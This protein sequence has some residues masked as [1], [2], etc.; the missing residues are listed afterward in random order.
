MTNNELLKNERIGVLLWK[1][2]VPAIIGMLVNALYNVVDRMYIG[3]L[4]P[5]AMTGIGLSLPLMTILMGFGMLVGIG[6]GAR[7]SIRL[8]QGRKEDAEHI[9]GNAFTLLTLIMI[10]V[11]ALGLVFKEPLLYLF[12]ASNATFDYANSYLTIILY[13]SIFQGLGFGLTGIMRSEGSPKMAMYTVIISA[14]VN[15]ILDP[16]LIFTFKMG[17]AGAAVA[18]I[19]SQFVSMVLV[20][21]HFTS[22]KSKLKLQ[23]KHL[24]LD[25]SIVISIISIGLSPFLMQIAASAVTIIANHA[26]KSAGGDLAISAMTVVN[27]IAIF[28]LMP[29]FG[30]NQGT[31]P[32]IGYNYG[33][34]QYDRVK[35]TLKLAI[36]AAAVIACFGFLMTQFLTVPLIKIFNDDPKLV[37]ITTKGMRIWLSML[38]VVSFQII[39]ANYFQAV[40]KAHKSIF[41]SLL[42]QVILLIPLLLILPSF[43]GLTGVWLA[44]PTADFIASVITA[45]FLFVEIRHLNTSHEETTR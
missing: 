42:R 19:F 14:L 18:T 12:G 28:F 2:S 34:K 24:K 15:I 30:I 32:I 1:F 26:L 31:Q 27:A 35:L 23:R 13:G 25:K 9:L 33:A 17:I 20:I 22:E 45:I 6:G 10:V 7:I 44:G 41:L 3:W 4:S 39:S 36:F 29:L 21:R 11:M 8:G 43:W 40:G 38:P 16:I 5:L 37:E